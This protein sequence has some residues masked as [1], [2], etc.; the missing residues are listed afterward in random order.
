M[1]SPRHPSRRWR[2]PGLPR[3]DAA[4]PSGVAPSGVAPSGESDEVSSDARVASSV[5]APR[6]EEREDPSGVV[7]TANATPEVDDGWTDDGWMEA[8]TVLGAPSYTVLASERAASRSEVARAPRVAFEA[9]DA[10][11]SSES[12]VAA[13]RA[14][15]LAL[16]F[17]ELGVVESA[18]DRNDDGD[19]A[20]AFE[21]SATETDAPSFLPES[22]GSTAEL[23][24]IEIPIDVDEPEPVALEVSIARQSESAIWEGLDGEVGVFFAT[25]DE[26]PIGTEVVLTVHLTGERP[27]ETR[28][29]VVWL[30]NAPGLW[31]GL[32]LRLLENRPDV[33]FR[34]QRFSQRWR[35]PKFQ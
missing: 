3:P 5:V 25:Y 4:S 9:R 29:R 26:L 23:P 8:R 14:P 24:S 21:A 30:R 15:R 12:F 32:G 7:P 28:A 13:T 16:P 10:S 27:F 2:E 6:R 1:T 19:D 17:A 11:A 31:P 33:W 34:I 22:A 35:A 18:D 20:L